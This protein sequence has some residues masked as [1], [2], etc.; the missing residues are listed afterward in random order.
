MTDSF[1]MELQGGENLR[2]KET[3][4]Y[5]IPMGSSRATDRNVFPL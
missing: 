1:K 5:N 3:T 4:G 2:S